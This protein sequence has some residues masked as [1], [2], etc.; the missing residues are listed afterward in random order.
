MPTQQQ[1]FDVRDA[2]E[3]MK[4]RANEYGEAINQKPNPQDELD[5]LIAAYADLV[6]KYDLLVN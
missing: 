5:A 3:V 6:Q 4:E 2:A 1:A